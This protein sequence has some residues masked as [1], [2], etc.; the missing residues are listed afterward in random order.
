MERGVWKVKRGEGWE[1]EREEMVQNKSEKKRGERRRACA[2]KR[3]CPCWQHV[4]PYKSVRR[5]QQGSVWAI[6]LDVCLSLSFV[7]VG[8]CEQAANAD[9]HELE[10][11]PGSAESHRLSGKSGCRVTLDWVV[12]NQTH[13]L[14]SITLEGRIR[15]FSLFNP[16]RLCCFGRLLLTRRIG[17]SVCSHLSTHTAANIVRHVKEGKVASTT[18]SWR[19]NWRTFLTCLI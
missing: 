8:V 18:R 6:I 12:C 13:H 15:T 4:T 9:R 14:I 2:W 11:Y 19:R 1:R 17:F 7:C 10:Y 5:A 16:R 3:V